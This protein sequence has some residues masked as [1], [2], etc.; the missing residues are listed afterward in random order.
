MKIRR[1]RYAALYGP[2]AGDRVRLGDTNLILEVEKD[3][4]IPGEEVVFGGGKTIRDGM[5]QSQRTRGEGAPDLVVTNAIV[6][7]WWGVVKADV[8]VRAGKICAIGKAGNR[9][10]GRRDAGARDRPFHQRSSPARQDPDGG[11]HRFAHPLHLPATSL[12]GAVLGVTTMLG[13]GTG[14]AEGSRPPPARRAGGTFSGC[15]NRSRR[16]R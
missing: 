9:T 11:R 10:S 4:A 12:G 2:T 3:Y 16:C 8:G 14:P 7:D 15:S 5:G 13:G 1:E 6:L